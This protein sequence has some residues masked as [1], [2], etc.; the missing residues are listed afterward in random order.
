MYGA[1]FSTLFGDVNVVGEI[2][3]IPDALVT[4]NVLPVK[5]PA[6]GFM[7]GKKH[8]GKVTQV[9]L[10][11]LYV[12]G[13]NWLADQINLTGEA[14]YVTTDLDEDD[15]LNTD[16]ASGYAIIADFNYNSVMSGLDLAVKTSFQHAVHG[17]WKTLTLVEDAKQAGIG[18]QA[19]YLKRWV[20]EIKYAVFWDA[21]NRN[22]KH[23][24]DNITATINYSF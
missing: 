10:S 16:D 2:S 1:S 5:D 23:D 21:E 24:R 7:D 4:Q 13:A 18:L 3:Y 8:E 20:A 17:N 12:W 15:M 9:N 11:A 14:V 19:T 6:G 22:N